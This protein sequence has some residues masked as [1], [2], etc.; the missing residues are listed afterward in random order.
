M[1]D[2]I[3]F[4]KIPDRALRVKAPEA[5]DPKGLLSPN[6]ALGRHAENYRRLADKLESTPGLRDH[7]LESAPLRFVTNGVYTTMDAYQCA[8]ILAAHD[9]RHV[10]Q[11]LE[12]KADPA[13][14]A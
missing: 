1:I 14:P 9:Q 4:A 11:M 8:L 2:A 10:L 6:E 5:I 3:I 7:V 13:Y 12:V